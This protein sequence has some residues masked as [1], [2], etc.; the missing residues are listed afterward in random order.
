MKDRN[1]ATVQTLREEVKPAMW[2]G[3]GTQDALKKDFLRH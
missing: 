3:S 1:P 2:A